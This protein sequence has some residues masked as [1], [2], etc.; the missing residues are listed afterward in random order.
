MSDISRLPFVGNN[1][2]DAGFFWNTTPNGVFSDEVI[3]GREYALQ[4]LDF[5]S[6]NPDP[7]MLF[8]IVAQ[9]NPSDN[10]NPLSGIEVGFLSVLSNYA[11]LGFQQHRGAK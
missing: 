5:I 1:N 8:T 3:L 7:T 11:A 4:F 2:P 6:N 9:F 10:S